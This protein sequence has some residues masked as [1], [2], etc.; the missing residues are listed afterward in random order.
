MYKTKRLQTLFYNKN[1]N[2]KYKKKPVKMYEA[3]KVISSV[4]GVHLHD[5]IGFQGQ[6]L[7]QYEIFDKVNKIEY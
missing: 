4:K 6:R 3:I 2:K 1:T 5:I 7:A